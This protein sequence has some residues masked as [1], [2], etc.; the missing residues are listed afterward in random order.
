MIDRKKFNPVR[1]LTF[2][3]KLLTGTVRGL[4]ATR[5]LLGGVDWHFPLDGH[6]EDPRKMNWTHRLFFGHKYYYRAITAAEPDANIEHLFR[7]QRAYP[8]LPQDFQPISSCTVSAGGDLMP[9][10]WI[11][12][13]TCQNLWDEAGEWFFD[14]DVVAANLE[15]PI[16]TTK[17][18]SYVPEVMLN[19]MYFNGD[20]ALWQVFTANGR[21]GNYNVLSTAN[22]HSLDQGVDGL[23]NTINFLQQKNIQHVGT[24]RTVEESYEPVIIERNGIKTGFVAATFSLN[25]LQLSE[26]EKHHCHHY[27]L[28]E[29]NPDVTGLVAQA[30]RARAAGAEF[31]IGMLHMGCAYQP[32]PSQQI[33]KNMHRICEAAQLDLVLGGHPHNVQ[34]FEWYAYDTPNGKKNAFIIYS[35]GDFIAYD[36]F[37]WCHLPLLLKFTL[38]AGMSAGKREV[39]ITNIDARLFYLYAQVIAGKV[40]SLQLKDFLRLM[41]DD[42]ELRNDMEA[43]REWQELKQFAAQYLLSGNLEH[44][45]NTQK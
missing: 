41:N 8:E 31:I 44:L 39:R 37:K 5:R 27:N 10:S 2:A 22:N 1:P 11:T 35:Q 18:A 26:N 7:S 12:P 9:Y 25:A 30:E 40:T 42:A 32:Y 6:H 28:N 19:N 33:I 23:R 20:E 16:A 14:A 34:P 17:P 15:T 4:F 24:A 45:I 43:Y 3:G 38:T 13:Q 29:E 36:I 21:Y